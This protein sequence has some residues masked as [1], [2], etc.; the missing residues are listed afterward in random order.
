[1][2]DMIAPCWLEGAMGTSLAHCLQKHWSIINSG[3]IKVVQ[4]KVSMH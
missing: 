2:D 3:A 4:P 1:M